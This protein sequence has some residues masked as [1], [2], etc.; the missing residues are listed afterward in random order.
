MFFIKNLRLLKTPLSL[1]ESTF[2]HVL[3]LRWGFITNVLQ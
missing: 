2:W 3:I 1:F